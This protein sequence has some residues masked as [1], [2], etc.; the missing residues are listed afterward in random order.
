MNQKIV[1]VK[2]ISCLY[3]YRYVD[4]HKRYFV[5]TQCQNRILKKNID[6]RSNICYSELKRIAAAAV[7]R[8]KDSIN[9]PKPIIKWVEEYILVKQLKPK[10]AK[11]Y[12]RILA[13]YSYDYNEN[14]SILSRSIQSGVNSSQIARTVKAFFSWL[15]QNGVSVLNPAANITIPQGKIRHRTLTQ[16]EIQTYYK[17]LAKCTPELQLFGRL[18]LETGARVSSVYS[19]RIGDLTPNGLYLKNIKCDRNYPMAVPLSKSTLQLWNNCLKQHNS[20]RQDIRIF[21]SSYHVLCSHLR[22]LL[23]DNFNQAQNI[24]RVVIHSLRHTAATVALQNGVSIDMV[25]RMLDHINI[26]TTMSIYAKASQNQINQ[27]Y[28]IL[29]RSLHV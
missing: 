25:S 3:C 26:H 14:L 10:T 12:R 7:K 4:G 17:E 28:N 29:F 6:V 11:A 8:L 19:I 15:I 20:I 2:G 21:K 22:K 5:K 9:R 16:K 18:L 23:N 24:E 13:N 27:A 1:S